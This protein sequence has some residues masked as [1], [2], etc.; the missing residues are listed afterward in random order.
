M[1]AKRIHLVRHG[2]VYNPSGV[3]YGRLPNFHLSDTGKLMARAAAQ[4]LKDQGFPIRAIFSS[5]LIRTQESA[6]PIEELFGLD[7]KTN[8]NL[9]EP[10]NVFEGRKLSVKAVAVRP[11]WWWHFR[12]PAKPAWGESFI[13]IIARMQEAISEAAESVKD[14]DVVLVTHQ[15]PIWIMHLHAAGE[16]LMHDPRK[17]RCSLSSITSFEFID[18]KLTEV[19]YLEPAAKLS[20]ID[21]GAV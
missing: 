18:G 11:H 9:I 1:P 3:L 17:R 13:D 14:G 19:G 12:N 5:P 20:A 21:R 4:E 8:E 2:E 6:K 10:W 15:L 7:S 16:K